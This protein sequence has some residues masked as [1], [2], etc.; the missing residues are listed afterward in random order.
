MHFD[1]LHRRILMDSL[2]IE[3]GWRIYASVIWPSLV[4]I[5]ACRLVGA[6]PLSEPMLGFYW[7]LRNK[8]LWNFYRYS[9]IFIQGNAFENVVCEMVSILS[10]PQCVKEATEGV[11]LHLASSTLHH[12][13]VIMSVSDH[14][15]HDYL[16]NRFKENIKPLRHWPLCEEFTSNRRP[17]TQE[18]FPFDDVIIWV[19]VAINFWEWKQQSPSCGARYVSNHIWPLRVTNAEPLFNFSHKFYY[20]SVA[21][22]I[23][24]TCQV[25]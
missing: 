6:K 14:Q 23:I 15:P 25:P 7:T 5:M 19:F 17:V 1:W 9:S 21:M 18:M 24:S 4:Q 16:L 22:N 20:K 2:I 13:D 12:S 10:R 11:S 8:L 3:A